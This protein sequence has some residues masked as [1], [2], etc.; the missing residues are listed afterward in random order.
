MS[1]FRS[2]EFINNHIANI[3]KPI[4]ERLVSRIMK[5]EDQYNLGSN[6]QGGPSIPVVHGKGKVNFASGGSKRGNNH[7]GRSPRR[8]TAIG[9]YK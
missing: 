6:V 4:E 1:V 9:H 8:L 2:R 5:I 3:V 7:Y